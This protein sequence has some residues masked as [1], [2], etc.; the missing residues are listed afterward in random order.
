[1]RCQPCLRQQLAEM[2]RQQQAMRAMQAQAN[3]T[4][5]QYRR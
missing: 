5:A 4:P 3:F 1:M 2:E